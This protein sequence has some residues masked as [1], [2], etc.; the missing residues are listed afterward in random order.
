ML[1]IVC[2]DLLELTPIVPRNHFLNICLKKYANLL[3][4]SVVRAFF[5]EVY[6]EFVYPLDVAIVETVEN[7]NIQ[8]IMRVQN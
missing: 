4:I 2:F 3:I 1:C 6:T 8:S 7:P 5:S